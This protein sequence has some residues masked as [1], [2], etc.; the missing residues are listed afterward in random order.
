M[1]AI[2]VLSHQCSIVQTGGHIRG[3]VWNNG[4]D[5][6][7]QTSSELGWRLGLLQVYL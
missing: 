2:L 1:H 5:R 7:I 3:Y 6:A 4:K